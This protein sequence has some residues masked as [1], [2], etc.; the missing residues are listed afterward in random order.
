[1][2]IAIRPQHPGLQAG[3]TPGLQVSFTPLPPLADLAVLWRDLEDRANGSFFNSWS[4]IGP[5]LGTYAAEAQAC[6]SIGLLSVSAGE[7]VVAVA[8]LGRRARPWH[9][10][11]ANAL[12]LHQTGRDDDTAAFIEYN[13]FLADRAVAREATAALVSY[14]ATAPI[15]AEGPW[16]LGSFTVAG[17]DAPLTSALTAGS[18][19]HCVT[20]AAQCP[21][22]DLRA[23]PE[24]LDGY[25]GRLSANT[26]GQI[27]RSV[28]LYEAQGPLRL[29]SAPD[30]PT[31]RASMRELRRLHE[32]TWTRRGSG[33]GAFSH[34]MF[35]YFTAAL[36]ETGLGEGRVDVL[37]VSAGD[38]T[39]G[40]LLNFVHAG[41][42]YAYQ[43]GLGYAVDNRLKP[44]LVTHAL[45]V[46][47]Y[48]ARGMKAYHFMAGDSRYKT[49]LGTEVE[50]LSWL[51]C[52]RDT[53]IERV[54]GLLRYIKQTTAGLFMV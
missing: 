17:A 12:F 4:W 41:H 32:E 24:G 21:W 53:M 7:S 48:R 51:T 2:N 25:L 52:H 36:V 43:S 23:Q 45:A 22:I 35:A 50:V 16:K 44:G 14:M 46:A 42:V 31:A 40:L 1:M 11:G 15:F 9:R 30:H 3:F 28:R 10:G 13:G 38:E 29:T 39:V 33:L 20:R 37:R 19:R 54:L 18:L 49:S 34:P 5:W 26:R 27:R 47:H 8:L 6:A